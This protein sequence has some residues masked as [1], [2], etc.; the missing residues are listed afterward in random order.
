L[1][2]NPQIISHHIILNKN[3]LYLSVFLKTIVFKNTAN[4]KL[5]QKNLSDA[6]HYQ[7][8]LQ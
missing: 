7:S 3:H 8:F 2:H 1:F 6:I 4:L 5:T